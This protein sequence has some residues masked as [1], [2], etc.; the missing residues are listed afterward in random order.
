MTKIRSALG[1]ATGAI[2]CWVPL[3]KKYK[4]YLLSLWRLEKKGI[5]KILYTAVSAYWIRFEYLG[6]KDPDKREAMKG[7]MMGGESGR[8][9]AKYYDEQAIDF[10]AKVG[11]L[12]YQEAMSS[13]A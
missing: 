6:E 1:L 7:L 3:F 13:T 12:T 4:L 11:S 2:I 5:D 10:E 9:W 8:E